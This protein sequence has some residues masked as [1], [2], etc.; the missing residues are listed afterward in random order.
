[1]KGD[2]KSLE[3]LN[4]I[5][6]AIQDTKGEEIK[7]LDFSDMENSVAD[8]SVICSANSNTQ[9]N[10]IAGKVEKNI[11]KELKDRPWHSEGKDNATWVLIDYVSVV[12][13]IF[14]K[15]V[16]E[17]YDIENLWSEAKIVTINT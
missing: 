5:I 9:V 4:K 10:A 8:Y 14:Q 7:V 11:R 6:E 13:H 2:I 16:R 17:Y 3:L 1:M 12:V 15:H